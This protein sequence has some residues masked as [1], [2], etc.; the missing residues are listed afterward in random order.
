[1]M[2]NYC[3]IYFFSGMSTITYYEIMEI[4]ANL[5]TNRLSEKVPPEEIKD[6]RTH[7]HII[8]SKEQTYCTVH[9]S[10]QVYQQMQPEVK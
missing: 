9:R 10:Q 7:N 5:E 6:A 3:V 2:K 4:D 1:M 8:K